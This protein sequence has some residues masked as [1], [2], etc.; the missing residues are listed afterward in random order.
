MTDTN[1]S[2]Q[3]EQPQ[4]AP[5]AFNTTTPTTTP[6]PKDYTITFI[7]PV[8]SSRGS[9]VYWFEA[10][11]AWAQERY[12]TDRVRVVDMAKLSIPDQIRVMTTTALYVSNHGGG[13]SFSFFLPRGASAILFWHGPRRFD[14]PFYE[15]VDHFRSTWI[16]VEERSRVNRTIA[17][18]ENEYEQS[19]T[20]WIK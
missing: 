17:M 7:L 10:E 4:P 9:E 18:I 12:G 14:Y 19:L 15:S 1:E 3:Q 20:E 16:G 11:I 2:R 6:R 13:S 5:G 8:G